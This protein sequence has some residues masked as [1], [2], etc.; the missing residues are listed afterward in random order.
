[1]EM[2]ICPGDRLAA[3]EVCRADY[4]TAGHAEPERP[5]EEGAGSS[6]DVVGGLGSRV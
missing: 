5:S 2:Q 1:M 4:G 6:G 3:A